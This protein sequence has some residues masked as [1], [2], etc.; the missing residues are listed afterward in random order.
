[1]YNGGKIYADDSTRVTTVFLHKDSPLNVFLGNSVPLLELTPFITSLRQSASE[2]NASFA[3]HTELYEASQPTPG[4]I[5]EIKL[6]GETYWIGP[7]QAVNDYRLASGSRAISVVARSRDATPAWR[8]VKRATDVYPTGTPISYIA[9]QIAQAI[10]LSSEEIT[11]P[12]SGAATVHSNTQLA[13]L[14][15]WAMLTTIYQPEGLEPYVDAL[16]RLKCISRDIARAS[17]VILTDAR[18]LISVTGSKSKPQLTEMR[19]KW[20][21]PNLTESA[22]QDRMLDRASVTAG[23]F[24]I[25]Q[26]RDTYF[27]QDQTQRARDT[28]MVVKQS[29][30]SG[31]LPVCR[32]SYEQLST[33]SG[34]ITLRTS[35][36]VPLL[37]TDAIAAKFIAHNTPDTV[38]VPSSG[39][40][41]L[42]VTPVGRRSEFYAD[43]VLFLTM[44]S[45]GTGQYEIWGTPFDYVHARNTTTAYNPEA[46][47]WEIA[48][49]EIE[50]DFVTSEL[51][52]QAF[53]ILELIYNY[54]SATAY[55]L[56]IV[57]DT[58]I[59]RGDIVEL[60]DK[61]RIYVTDYSRDLSFGAPAVL[62]LQGFRAD[63][64][65]LTIGDPLTT[66]NVPA[67]TAHGTLTLDPDTIIVTGAT[68]TLHI[69][70]LTLDYT[71]TAFDTTMADITQ[72][73]AEMVNDT[74]TQIVV[75]VGANAIDLTISGPV[76]GTLRGEIDS[77]G[78]WRGAPGTTTGTVT[79]GV[80]VGTVTPTNRP[81]TG[82][83]AGF[84]FTMD[85]DPY[86][87]L[88]PR[89]AALAPNCQLGPWKILQTKPI[90]TEGHAAEVVD[91]LITCALGVSRPY[92]T[93]T[94]PEKTGTVEKLNPDTGLW[95]VDANDA[96]PI[97]QLL[98]GYTMPSILKDG[99]LIIYGTG[100][101]HFFYTYYPEGYSGPA[102]VAQRWSVASP[103]PLVPDTQF[104]IPYSAFGYGIALVGDVVYCPQGGVTFDYTAGDRGTCAVTPTIVDNPSR[105]VEA[106]GTNVYVIGCGDVTWIL[107]TLTNTY[108]SGAAMPLAI[109]NPISCVLDG[110]IYVASGALMSDLTKGSNHLWAYDP[111]LNTWT[112]KTPL[113]FVTHYVQFPGLM[114]FSHGARSGPLG[115][116]GR[117]WTSMTAHNGKIYFVGSDET[118]TGIIDG[119]TIFLPPNQTGEVECI[120]FVS[121]AYRFLWEARR[122]FCGTAMEYDPA[123]DDF[124]PLYVPTAPNWESGLVMASIVKATATGGAITLE[125]TDIVPSIT[126][127]GP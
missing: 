108:T 85:G 83:V 124:D 102:P 77:H 69:G 55:N 66:I 107:D 28:Y 65:A 11:L 101:V 59:E 97:R 63:I 48:P 26:E 64:A 89:E 112:E 37:A 24:Q 23:F 32:E 15:P 50:N 123:L 125:G 43:V 8:D 4:Q 19:I 116:I 75:G 127:S 71:A 52:A 81:M 30:N 94:M 47:P 120:N 27:S 115:P 88:K 90:A 67:T 7:I 79:D 74:V 13:E 14:S 42:P 122:Q 119:T 110:K 41:G 34:K 54:R 35:A 10:G 98:S 49:Q 86:L 53:A 61:S 17:D 9:T 57:D 33:T 6:E 106:V 111:V 21:D 99:R 45:I 60:A 126:V 80:F 72:A 16:G 18:R 40:V 113:P 58:R 91:G 51:Q 96:I 92:F 78:K 38:N 70:S 12:L 82:L 109:Q 93:A 56:E 105:A 25:K 73:L 22:Q 36:W 39:G 2:V 62:K 118:E 3:W 20:L 117:L 104:Y 1:M 95:T 68:Y 114:K 121:E 46:S 5:L 100:G 44:M 76:H 29:A 31:L 103:F 87:I 84:L